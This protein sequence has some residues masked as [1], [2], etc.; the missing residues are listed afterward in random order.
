MEDS[1]GFTEVDGAG[2]VNITG[3]AAREIIDVC[4]RLSVGKRLILTS[5]LDVGEPWKLVRT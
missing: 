5:R 4:G 3:D 1:P 2:I